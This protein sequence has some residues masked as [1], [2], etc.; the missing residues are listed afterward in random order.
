MPCKLRRS[1]E[2]IYNQSS[3]CREEAKRSAEEKKAEDKQRK[4]EARAAEKQRKKLKADQKKAEALE[5]K[6]YP[7]EDLELLEE[8]RAAAGLPGDTSLMLM[9]D[10]SK[11]T[12]TRICSLLKRT[13]GAHLL[14]WLSWNY[15]FY[16][17]VHRVHKPGP[18]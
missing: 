5:A 17:S 18:R 3:I 6:R 4:E 16:Q 2:G 12:H 1:I 8:T 11:W 10:L 14:E 7:M 15:V 13:T 9:Q